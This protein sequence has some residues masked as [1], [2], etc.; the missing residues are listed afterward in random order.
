M[1]NQQRIMNA[2]FKIIDPERF[3]SISHTPGEIDLQGRFNPITSLMLK[4]NKFRE[5]GLDANGYFKMM[6]YNIVVTLTE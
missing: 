1:K 2:L 3:Y 4:Q 6:R 5:V